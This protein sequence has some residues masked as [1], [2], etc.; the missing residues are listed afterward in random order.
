VPAGSHDD[1]VAHLARSTPLSPS[2]ASRVVDEVLGYFT[3]LLPDYVRR[4]HTELKRR[5]L[6]ND[7]IFEELAGEVAARRFV[8]PPLSARQLRRIVYG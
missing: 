6:T 2:E 1:L 4:R 8:P 3:E 7:Q 5:G